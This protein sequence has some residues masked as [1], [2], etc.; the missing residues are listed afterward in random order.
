MTLLQQTPQFELSDANDFAERL[1]GLGTVSPTK[2][3][4]SERDQNFLISSSRGQFVLKISN[5][6]ESPESLAAQNA[7]MA[8][9]AEIDG[10]VVAQS[11]RVVNSLAGN[12]IEEVNGA[13]GKRHCV[14]LMSFVV[15]QPMASLPCYCDQL[16][17]HL[18]NTIGAVTKS[19]EGF[20][21]PAFRYDF[22]WDL[23]NCVSVIESRLDLIDGE[24]RHM[25]E[26]LLGRFKRHTVPLVVNL[27]QSVIHNDANDGNLIVEKTDDS[28]VPNRIAGVI[29]FGDAVWSW[30]IGELAIAIAYAVLDHADPIEA[31]C[32]IVDGYQSEKK[33]TEDEAAALFGLVCMRLCTSVVMAAEQQVQRPDDQYLSIS[34]AP[35]SRTLPLLVEVPF[36]FAEVMI[37]ERCGLPKS[38]R[39]IP[40]KDW[41][42]GQ[43]GDFV[44]PV[45]ESRPADEEMLVM[46][47]GVESPHLIGPESITVPEMS[48]VIG[49]QLQAASAKIAVGR[50]LEPRLLYASALFDAG[51]RRES[52]TIHLGMDL[53]DVAGTSIR[54]PLDGEVFQTANNSARLDYGGVV[55]LK[56]L[57][58]SGDE[59]FSLYG[60]LAPDS[61]GELEPGQKVAAGEAFAV[62]GEPHENGGWAP[63]LHFQLIVD[64]FGLGT[65][66]PGVCRASRVSVWRQFCP[67]PNLILKI[68]A[69]K[70]PPQTLSKS[71]T[72]E[73][74]H[75][76]MGGNLSVGYSKPLK[77]VRGWKQ[78][79]YDENG[80]KFI[81][82]YNNV[83]HVGH[84]HPRVV[85]A[86]HSQARLLNTNTRYLSDGVLKYAEALAETMPAGLDVCYFLNSASE[87][88][89]LA[90]RLARAKT[91]GK[92]LIVLEG[93]YHG[94][95][96]TLIDISPYKH[97]GPGGSG[98]ADWV[99]TAP[100][101]DIFR[102][103][104]KDPKTA[105][106]KYAQSIG[107]II[108]RV[109]QQGRKVSGF[110]A[111]SCPSVGGQIM[112]PD[113]Y[114][115]DVYRRIREVG[116][117]CI[118][119]DVQTGYGR[120]GKWFYGFEQQKVLPDIVVL[121]KPI[122]NGHPIAALV[123]TR[124]IAG[125]FANGM[126]FF[127][128][129]GGNTVSAVVGKTVLDIVKEEGLA[130]HADTVGDFL[131]SK[132]REL[133]ERYAIIGDVRGSGLF[134][135]V[136]LVRDRETLEPA[137]L[138]T[139]YVADRMR[140]RRIL[141][142]TDGPLHN[143]LKIRPPMPFTIEDAKVLIAAL[144]QTFSELDSTA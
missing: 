100:V 131:L 84:C 107:E 75:S 137:E 77:A 33:L 15:G 12:P 133:K 78:Y 45:G 104:H 13:D 120:L 93:A 112:F 10:Q 128:T 42:A 101:A 134:L 49:E 36:E 71:T 2:R 68:P 3:L 106:G 90:L 7:M 88:N 62:L 86:L 39:T 91:G 54:A 96:T 139:R 87:A 67:D 28:L 18:G 83:P 6:T 79:L 132:L 129:F 32:L 50:Y 23:A 119:D 110:I 74:R 47:L 59:F 94:H 76:R 52:R 25:V 30:T 92:D 69:E 20:D 58:D 143:V 27:P 17:Q 61:F 43:A 11:V 14:R 135:G 142:G 19:L 53:F 37:K 55:I 81:D 22:H 8:R 123:T 70:F 113:G 16:L 89:E 97:D 44:F 144:D 115:A 116:G 136:E 121:G 140:E 1:F 34:Q 122:G 29:D 125:S 130:A 105:G 21:D 103:P 66:F 73:K 80:Q 114:L 82:A 99:H 4:A 5:A 111:E 98:P 64:L 38:D 102:G 35:I 56:H 40:V 117:L 60:H 109:H 126:E 72:L 48:R 63:H 141:I 85:A 51:D 65:N 41:L 138:E 46:D 31:M 24:K 26:C 118:A 124:E 57:T 9:L 95:S 127:S 108:A